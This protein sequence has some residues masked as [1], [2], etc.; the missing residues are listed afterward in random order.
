MIDFNK[1]YSLTKNLNILYIEDDKNFSEETTDAFTDIFKSVSLAFDGEEGLHLYNN[2][3]DKENQYY[4]IVITDINMPSMDGLNLIKNIYKINPQQIIIIISAHDTQE[5]LLQLVNIGIEQ[6]LIKPL[7]YDKLLATF[8]DSANKLNKKSQ[9]IVSS[10]IVKLGENYTFQK[11]CE[12][13][14]YQDKTIKL[15]KKEHILIKLFIKNGSKISLFEEIFSL[16]WP[17][18]SYLMNHDT[19]KPIISRLRK[20]IPEVVIENIYGLG[21]KIIF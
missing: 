2:Y 1:V 9:D 18:E 19:L 10:N 16:L 13:L 7:E 17:E 8:Y 6:F 20:K 12:Q 3:F 11:D 4:D 5:N 21:Y 14:F 15:T